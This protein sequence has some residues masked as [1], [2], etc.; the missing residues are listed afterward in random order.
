MD[1]ETK[2]IMNNFFGI[3]RNDSHC[4]IKGLINGSYMT[5]FTK[6]RKY[7]SYRESMLYCYNE[8][9]CCCCDDYFPKPGESH[10]VDNYLYNKRT[11]QLHT[12]L[13]ILCKY[14]PQYLEEMLEKD[15]IGD[16]INSK[17]KLE[18]T[19]LHYLCRYSPKYLRILINNK[20]VGDRLLNEINLCRNTFIHI[21]C[22]FNPD[23]I[24]EL[25]DIFYEWLDSRDRNDTLKLLQRLFS[26]NNFNN[27][28]FTGILAKYHPEHFFK[29]LS[30]I[31][32]RGDKDI[33]TYIRSILTCNDIKYL[34]AIDRKYS[35]KF[36]EICLSNNIPISGKSGYKTNLFTLSH[37]Y[38]EKLL[39]YINDTTIDK[40]TVDV[41][42]RT[43]LHIL[44]ENHI[45]YFFI[46]LK[47]YRNV[48]TK[49]ELNSLLI[50]ESCDKN[51]LFLLCNLG[52]KYLKAFVDNKFITRELIARKNREG[53]SILKLLATKYIDYFF[54]LLDNGYIDNEL[55]LEQNNKNMTI[56][57]NIYNTNIDY[58]YKFMESRYITN[59][60]LEKRNSDGNTV[61]HLL[62]DS[63]KR[64][65]RFLKFDIVK[66]NKNIFGIQNNKNYTPLHTICELNSRFIKQI[67]ES[68]MITL[69]TLKKYTYKKETV[70]HILCC[71]NPK[72]IDTLL[73]CDHINN[74]NM[75]EGI[76]WFN[77]KDISDYSCLLYVCMMNPQYIGSILSSKFMTKGLFDHMCNNNYNVLH[78]ICLE[79]PTFLNILLNS[80]FM[81]KDTFNKRSKNGNTCLHNLCKSGYIIN[82]ELFHHKYMLKSQYEKKNWLESYAL[83]FLEPKYCKKVKKS[84][85]L[86]CNDELLSKVYNKV[87]GYYSYEEALRD[88]RKY[89]NAFKKIENFLLKTYFKP[90]SYYYKKTLKSL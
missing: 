52:V 57:H 38:P 10:I 82:D 60:L 64:L 9:D 88:K 5:I 49:D 43:F 41:C 18:N 31:D 78:Y 75:K 24:Y 56:L 12:C 16:I 26:T 81:D 3:L 83:E 36:I 29:L 15:F 42:G 8:D 45:D 19:C 22:R 70:L 40:N 73:S 32:S 11:K 61:L 66:N 6:I 79:N 35:E 55:L 4:G 13:H 90:G 23:Y 39:Q 71:C 72:Y 44:C 69:D 20:K 7:T 46:F 74:M 68:N 21:L 53:D 67:L 33:I 85:M 77:R 86:Y 51:I 50:A 48:V 54:E 65:E 87:F 47:K 59:E 27:L 37:Y 80:K 2:T 30:Y 84:I 58:F 28:Y 63:P 17:E 25:F 76:L 14:N 62:C 1:K 89:H 34:Y